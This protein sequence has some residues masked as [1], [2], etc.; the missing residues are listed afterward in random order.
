MRHLRVSVQFRTAAALL[1]LIWLT[2]C[3]GDSPAQPDSLVTLAV[4][5]GKEM[6][7]HGPAGPGTEPM[8]I[9]F[10]WTVAL[11]VAGGPGVTVRAIRTELREPNYAGRLSVATGPEAFNGRISPGG[12]LLVPQSSSGLF[13]SALYPG[14]WEANA[15]VDVLHPNGKAE[16]L[17]TAFSFR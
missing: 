3:D 2:G 15:S 13:S 6:P 16:T 5:S 12:I 1:A 17:Q 14:Q 7:F 8:S 10:Q 4:T 11:T 9:T